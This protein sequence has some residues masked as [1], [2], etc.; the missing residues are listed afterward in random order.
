MNQEEPG[1]PRRTQEPGVQEDKEE[2]GGTRRSQKDPGGARRSPGRSQEEPGA[3]VPLG[4]HVFP[5][6]QLQGSGFEG[7]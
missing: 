4:P 6:L 7:T 5:W 3:W 1:G 2:P